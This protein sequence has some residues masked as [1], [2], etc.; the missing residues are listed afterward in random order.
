M[1][2]GRKPYY[3]NGILKKILFE[4]GYANT[5]HEPVSVDT[6][7]DEVAKAYLVRNIT[8]EKRPFH[9][10]VDMYFYGSKE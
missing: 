1:I 6:P 3:E 8:N 7:Y 4:G 2:Q 5:A 9:M 10:V